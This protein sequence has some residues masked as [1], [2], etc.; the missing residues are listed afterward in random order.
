MGN[1]LL[2]ISRSGALFPSFDVMRAAAQCV[3]SL[4]SMISR[5]GALRANITPNSVKL[6]V[7]DVGCESGGGLAAV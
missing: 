1:M 4:K 3:T 2:F 6:Q 5:D 7:R